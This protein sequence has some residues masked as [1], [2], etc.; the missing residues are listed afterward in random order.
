M[1]E[2]VSYWND[3]RA[4]PGKG[5]MRRKI[6]WSLIWGE[7]IGELNSEWELRKPE[8]EANPRVLLH[9]HYWEQN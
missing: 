1:D 8:K 7:D 5:N 9:V 3:D 2:E 6:A 4:Y